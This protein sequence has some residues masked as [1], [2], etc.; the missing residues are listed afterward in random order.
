MESLLDVK[1]FYQQ[2]WDLLKVCDKLR[3][4]TLPAKGVKMVDSANHG[5][6]I[7]FEEEK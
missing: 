4:E 3:D 5:T 7:K 1:I 2:D 6:L